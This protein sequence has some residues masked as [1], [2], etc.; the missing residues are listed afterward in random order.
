MTNHEQHYL[1][2]ECNWFG[3]DPGE[4]RDSEPLE[5]HGERCSLVTITPICPHCGMDVEERDVCEACHAG[6]A[7][8]G[9]SYC[10]A[11]GREIEAEDY[12]EYV[13][14]ERQER[15]HMEAA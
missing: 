11:C 12:G 3:T 14:A 5:F 2:L 8:D 13:V 1:C 10:F 15:R 6:P 9:S 7:D 4:I